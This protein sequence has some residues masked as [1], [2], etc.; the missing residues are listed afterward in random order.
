MR[1]SRVP[2]LGTPDTERVHLM[3]SKNSIPKPIRKA[4]RNLREPAKKAGKEAA[5][6]FILVLGKT[7]GGK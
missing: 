5:V 3:A 6:T 4:A 2:V 7:L 1:F